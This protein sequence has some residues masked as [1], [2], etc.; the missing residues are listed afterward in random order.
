MFINKL[1]SFIS[2]LKKR[3]LNSHLIVQVNIP[4]KWYGS[5]Y[6]G[7][8]LADNYINSNSIVYSFGIGKDITF[9]KELIERK[10]CKIYAFDPTPNSIEWLSKQQLPEGFSYFDY[11][12]S[13]KSGLVN[14]YLPVN[15]DFVSGSINIHENVDNHS[16]IS[17]KMKSFIDIT[18]T[19]KHNR[20]DLIKMDIEGAEYDVIDNILDSNI[21]VNQIL[22]EIHDRFYSEGRKRSKMLLEKLNKKG[23]KIFAVSESLE[24]ISFINTNDII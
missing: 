11:G 12:I 8:Y 20:I 19:L 13:T 22:V 23:F 7:F 14:F 17:V 3:I 4:C 16:Y 5:E 1:R 10:L 9:D 18:N 21:E 24:E 15:P 6:G 2:K